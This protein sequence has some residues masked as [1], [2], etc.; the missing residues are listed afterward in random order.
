MS[1]ILS[2]VSRIA[3]PARCPYAINFN[4]SK[5]SLTSPALIN[6]YSYQVR[7]FQIKSTVLSYNPNSKPASINRTKNVV[8]KTENTSASSIKCLVCNK[9]GHD[10]LNCSE[11][12]SLNQRLDLLRFKNHVCVS[13]NQS[14][15]SYETCAEIQPIKQKLQELEKLTFIRRNNKEDDPKC[16]ESQSIRQ[17]IRELRKLDK[18]RVKNEKGKKRCISCSEDGHTYFSCPKVEPLK[19]RLEELKKLNEVC[20]SCSKKGHSY[21]NCSDVLPMI[22]K[23]NELKAKSEKQASHQDTGTEIY[24][25][26]QKLEDLNQKRLHCLKENDSLESQFLL[27]KLKKENKGS[28]DQQTLVYANGMISLFALERGHNKK[29]KSAAKN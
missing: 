25:I 24:S 29:E 2:Q 6:S 13:C 1:K 7:S 28:Q 17:K 27:S 3:F 5:L 20:V 11:I 21:E 4:F 10:F 9:E 26:K 16:A 19:K 15:H 23:L 18:L 14:G 22:Q 8:R 12:N